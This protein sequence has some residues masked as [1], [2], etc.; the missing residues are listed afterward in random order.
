MSATAFFPSRLRPVLIGAALAVA[1]ASPAAWAHGGRAMQGPMGFGLGPGLAAPQ[2]D[3]PARLDRWLDHMAQT[4]Q[5]QPAQRDEIRR[6][7]QAAAQD[8]RP[9][10][11]EARSLHE[12]RRRLWTQTTLDA[13]AVETLRQRTLALHDRLSA[14]VD[15]TLLDIGRVLTPQQRQQLADRM[16][17]RAAHRQGAHPGPRA[18]GNG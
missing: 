17:H 18:G 14:R 10:R 13:A 7:A 9:L 11:D 8:L 6:I 15:R 5:L 1:A 4:L 2:A 3:D 16:A 12:E